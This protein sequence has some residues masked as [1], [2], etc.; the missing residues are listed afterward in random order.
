MGT[1]IQFTD[2][3]LYTPTSWN[4]SFPGGTPAT[5][6]EQHPSV[7]YAT[8]GNYNITLEVSDGTTTNTTTSNSFVQVMVSPGQ[9]LPFQEGFESATT[10]PNANWSVT[11]LAGDGSFTVRTDASYSGSKSIR[12][13]NHGVNPGV[14]DELISAPIDLSALTEPP[15]LSFR[16]AYRRRAAGNTDILR[17][18]VSRDCGETWAIRSQLQASGVLSTAPNGSSFFTPNNQSQWGYR[19]VTNINS[20]YFEEHARIK[21]EF[22]SGGGNNLWL[23]DININGVGVGFESLGASDAHGLTV[24]PNPLNGM[25]TVVIDM[26]NAAKVRLE[27]LDALGRKVMDQGERQ[28]ARGEQ[29]WELPADGLVQGVYFVR[30]HWADQVAITR[31]VRN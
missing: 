16:Y 4:W 9:Q 28:L 1:T 29:R 13:A 2:E 11:D 7:S 3:S 8:P 31:F 19:E 25:G 23:D 5:S 17:V 30:M 6:Q 22:I 15:V 14:I 12:L 24:L 10:L 20:N 18:Y 27:A 21:F 26:P